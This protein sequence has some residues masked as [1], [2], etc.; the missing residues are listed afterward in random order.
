VSGDGL[1]GDL[2]RRYRRLLACY[3]GEHRAVYQEEMLGVLLDGAGPDRRWPTAGETVSLLADAL[4]SRWRRLGRQLT[5]ARW[6]DAIAIVSLIAPAIPLVIGI[7]NLILISGID[8]QLGYV[9]RAPHLGPSVWGPPV[10]WALVVLAALTGPRILAAAL[11]WIALLMEAGIAG[12]EYQRFGLGARP[13][14]WTLLIALVAALA[15]TVGPGPRVAPRLLGPWRMAALAALGGFVA[16]AEVI[17]RNYSLGPVWL[18]D[19][20]YGIHPY[21]PA[22]LVCVVVLVRIGAPVRRRLLAVLAPLALFVALD[23]VAGYLYWHEN[24]SWRGWYD[25]ALSGVLLLLTLSTFRLSVALVAR[26]E[27]GSGASGRTAV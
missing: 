21:G 22:V 24:G 23:A 27:R 2:E 15:L 13:P 11:G 12:L 5:A 14:E 9:E 20:Y 10:G 6:R 1:S 17:T 26:R 4:R 7:R 16:A 18:R 3:P 25:V 8:A 19:L